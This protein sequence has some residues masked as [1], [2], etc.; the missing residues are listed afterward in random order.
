MAISRSDQVEFAP[1]RPTLDIEVRAEAQRMN[2]QRRCMVSSA[3]TDARLMI[4]TKPLAR[5]S[6]KPI[7]LGRGQHLRRPAQVVRHEAAEE[8]LDREPPFL[9]GEIRA[10]GARGPPARSRACRPHPRSGCA[11]SR[12][13]RRASASETWSSAGARGRPDRSRKVRS[14]SRTAGRRGSIRLPSA[15]RPVEL[16]RGQPL[17]RIAVDRFDCAA[18]AALLTKAAMAQAAHE[19]GGYTPFTAP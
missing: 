1:R 15:W 2:R 3:A 7:A 19:I 14:R 17:H 8:R 16:F 6:V 5:E 13:A 10:H 12:A 11:A 4:E 9:G 18:M